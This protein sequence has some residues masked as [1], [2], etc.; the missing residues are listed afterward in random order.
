[1]DYDISVL[2]AEIV[3]K[4]ITDALNVAPKY[5]HQATLLIPYYLPH[6]FLTS[7]QYRR[8]LTPYHP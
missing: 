2:I 7:S 6:N 5:P 3:E 1:M 8:V 4:D